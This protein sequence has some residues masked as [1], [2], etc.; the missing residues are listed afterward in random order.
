VHENENIK[1]VNYNDTN[2]PTRILVIDIIDVFILMHYICYIKNRVTSKIELLNSKFDL[3]SGAAN[4]GPLMYVVRVR[5]QGCDRFKGDQTPVHLYNIYTH[6]M[7]LKISV[8]LADI[9]M[10]RC[11]GKLMM[12]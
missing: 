9:R 8:H 1:D 2:A 6:T 7:N 4:F 10:E 12:S 5:I 11:F 3:V